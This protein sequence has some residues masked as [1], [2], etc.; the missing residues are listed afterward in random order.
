MN[1]I[2]F[3]KMNFACRPIDLDSTKHILNNLNTPCNEEL[4]WHQSFIAEF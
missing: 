4:F 2:F 1:Y 3:A